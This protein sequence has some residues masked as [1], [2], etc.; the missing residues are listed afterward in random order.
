MEIPGARDKLQPGT[1][2][3]MPGP[4]IHHP[5]ASPDALCK[6]PG[7]PLL[8]PDT[9]LLAF[10]RGCLA[11]CQVKMFTVLLFNEKARHEVSTEQCGKECVPQGVPR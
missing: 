2:L 8:A 10:R 4:V 7:S 5:L 9:A 6:V 11:L 1:A 3:T